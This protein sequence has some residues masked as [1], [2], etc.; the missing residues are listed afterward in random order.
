MV[1]AVIGIPMTALCLASLGRSMANLFRVL[2]A[3]TFLRLCVSDDDRDKVWE[4]WDYLVALYFCFTTLSTIGFGDFVPGSSCHKGK[5]N[6]QGAEQQTLCVVYLAIGLALLGKPEEKP[7]QKSAK[8]NPQDDIQNRRHG[9]D[10]REVHFSSDP[11]SEHSFKIFYSGFFGL[12]VIDL[13]VIVD[14][15]HVINFFMT[16]VRFALFV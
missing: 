4:G 2:Y 8:S 15:S 7:D 5:Q 14:D 12:G 11:T 3:K 1:Y 16:S 6:D 13:G 9:K 10:K